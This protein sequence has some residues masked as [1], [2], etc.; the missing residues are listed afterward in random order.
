[1][2]GLNLNFVI[3][4]NG[5]ASAVWQP[6]PAFQSYPDRLHGGVIATLLDSAIVHAL[7]AINVA[8]VTAELT[9]RYLKSV[10]LIDPVRVTGRV[11]SKRHGLYLCEAEIYQNK[12]C[13]VRASAKFMTLASPCL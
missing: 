6:S 1:M 8:G 5:M 11:I 7:F 13:A 9:I 3:N 10:G 12:D 4:T 2:D